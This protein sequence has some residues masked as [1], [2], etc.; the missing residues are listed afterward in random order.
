VFSVSFLRA[1]TNISTSNVSRA[2]VLDILKKLVFVVKQRT[3]MEDA[4]TLSKSFC[5]IVHSNG[6]SEANDEEEDH[7]KRS[8][9][10]GA[11]AN[12]GLDIQI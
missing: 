9:P 12:E 10:L 2:E 4:T 11:I 1:M 3:I 8:N 7:P 5:S 6:R